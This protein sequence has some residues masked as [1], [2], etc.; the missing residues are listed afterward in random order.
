MIATTCS[1]FYTGKW[2]KIAKAMSREF[3]GSAPPNLVA[4]VAAIVR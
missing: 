1:A 3:K 2:N 4:L